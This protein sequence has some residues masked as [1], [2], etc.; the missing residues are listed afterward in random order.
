MAQPPGGG[1]F[2]EADFGDKGRPDPVNSLPGSVIAFEGAGVPLCEIKILAEGG[3][4][5]IIKTGTDAPSV[6][7]LVLLIIA[8]E[9]GAKALALSGGVREPGHDEFLLP[10]AFDFEPLPG[11]LLFIDGVRLFRNQAFPSALAGVAKED[12]AP[13]VA[14][15]E[16]AETALSDKRFEG[17]LPFSQGQACE[18]EAVEVQDIEDISVNGNPP[19]QIRVWMATVNPLLEFLETGLLVGK[20]NDLAIK[21]VVTRQCLDMTGNFRINRVLACAVPGK[22]GNLFPAALQEAALAIQLSFK[23]PVG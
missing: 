15:P 23:D 3:K 1:P 2:R 11:P 8:D 19:A 4:E 20:S 12:P 5:F 7:E 13:F 22:E 9:K 18:P 21:D 17:L 6:E 16:I 14:V 10:A